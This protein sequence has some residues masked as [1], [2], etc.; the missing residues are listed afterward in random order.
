MRWSGVIMCTLFLVLAA[1]L[2]VSLLPTWLGTPLGQ[3]F[4]GW[5]KLPW[6]LGGAVMLAITASRGPFR[7][8][9]LGFRSAL[10]IALDVTNWLRMHPL[11]RNPRARICARYV[12]L[13][14]HICRWTH[15]V[16]GSHYRALVIVAHSQGTVI[17]TELLT[18]LGRVNAPDLD[19][20]E[21]GASSNPLP[22][23]LLTAGCPLRQLYSLRFPHLYGWARHTAGQ[24]PGLVPDP[25][26]LRVECWYNVYRSGDYVGRYL[27]HADE[28]PE[29]WSC[30]EQGDGARR[31]ELCL[32]VGAHTHY[33]DETAKR[34]ADILDNM[35]GQACARLYGR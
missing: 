12:S 19:R 10:D 27:W 1:R 8:L 25:S 15:P 6:L 11:Q 2:V 4:S 16:D 21:P 35:I 30:S 13:L 18:F 20:L 34:V 24:W 3:W 7:F 5:P 22:V 32:G 9:A 26:D 17:T 31:K 14:R 33:F 29:R 28:G 23:Y